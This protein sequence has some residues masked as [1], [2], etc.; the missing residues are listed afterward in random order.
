MTSRFLGILSQID[1]LKEN[2]AT[3]LSAAVHSRHIGS[4]RA[5]RIK[6]KEHALNFAD[7]QSSYASGRVR[8]F[9]LLDQDPQFPFNGSP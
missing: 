6:E 4:S 3:F 7:R 2:V 8:Y 5:Q 9:R 1:S